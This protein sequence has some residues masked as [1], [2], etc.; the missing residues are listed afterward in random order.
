MLR[1]ITGKLLSDK[2]WLCLKV[3]YVLVILP[4]MGIMIYGVTGCPFPTG[5]CR[6]WSFSPLFTTVGKPLLLSV[7]VMAALLYIMEVGMLGVTL[8]LFLL[9]CI[10][11]SAHE[12]NGIF[13]R[14][15]VISVIWGG[16]F[17][18]YMQKRFNPSFHLQRF[19]I[20][21]SIQLIA[22]VYTLAA[23]A[24]LQASGV[25]WINAGSLFPLQV[26]KNFAYM[27]FDSGSQHVM[28][29]GKSIAYFLLQYTLVSKVFLA[30]ALALELFC[31]AAVLGKRWR[32]AFGIGLLLMHIGIAAVMGIGMSVISKPM[33]VFFLNPLYA[34]WLLAA[35]I[36]GKSR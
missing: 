7:Y 23:I 25:Q 4:L 36:K 20:N 10:I 34:L 32:V 15:T 27:Y 21:Y 12:S 11:I 22:A 29:Q 6:L 24:K 28:E 1:Q 26:M 16:Q 35:Y 9:S 5:V 14:A 3:S 31:F 30:I 8:L 13:F 17:L 2:E 33:I 19:R 18:A